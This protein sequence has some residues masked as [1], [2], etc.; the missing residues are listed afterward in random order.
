M[1]DGLEPG[2]RGGVAE[3]A[4][5][6]PGTIDGAVAHHPR[7]G[8]G[9]GGDGAPAGRQQAVNRGVSVVDRQPQA[10]E[11][12]RRRRL[13]NADRSGQPEDLHQLARTRCTLRKSSSGSSGRPR[14]VK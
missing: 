13:S 6:K 8:R 11:H 7:K 10:A 4:G 3:H 2:K 12:G 1:H 5:A 9:D 14:T